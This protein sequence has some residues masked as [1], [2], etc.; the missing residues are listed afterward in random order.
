M[1][2][3]DGRRPQYLQDI[4]YF[5]KI[6]KVWG[7]QKDYAQANSS[8]GKLGFLF[9]E[10]FNILHSSNTA[11]FRVSVSDYRGIFNDY[12][13]ILAARDS[14]VLQTDIHGIV[15]TFNHS[16]MK[17]V[18]SLDQNAPYLQGRIT[19][20]IANITPSVHAKLVRDG[21]YMKNIHWQNGSLLDM[22]GIW[23]PWQLFDSKIDPFTHVENYNYSSH[24]I[25]SS[26][27]PVA[28]PSGT[29]PDNERISIIF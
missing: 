25:G 14:A 1:R 12:D 18:A 17:R 28:T 7:T 20:P 2:V 8:A 27:S 15:H 9:L 21:A 24:Y 4:S 19:T 6:T 23:N 10:R 29:H 11:N 13:A 3:G 16:R 5:N 22:S 26:T